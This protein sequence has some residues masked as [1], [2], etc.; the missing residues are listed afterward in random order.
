MAPTRT[1]RGRV[2]EARPGGRPKVKRQKPYAV[3]SQRE[4]PSTVFDTSART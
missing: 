4:E 1:T 2:V 3:F